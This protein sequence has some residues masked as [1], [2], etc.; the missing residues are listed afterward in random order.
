MRATG[1]VGVVCLLASCTWLQAQQVSHPVLRAD[2]AVE[3]SSNP[4]PFVARRAPSHPPGLTSAAAL[5]QVSD[6]NVWLKSGALDEPTPA[7]SDR[8]VQSASAELAETSGGLAETPG[9]G[10][11]LRNFSLHGEFTR[12]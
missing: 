2:A 7:N 8:C 3:S 12:D 9:G 6:G 4:H 10:L 1:T 11:A 5:Q